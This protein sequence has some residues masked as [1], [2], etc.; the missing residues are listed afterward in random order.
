M[1]CLPN[2]RP[3]LPQPCSLCRLAD[4]RVLRPA[5]RIHIRLRGRVL[6][7]SAQ[8]ASVRSAAAAIVA[9][10]GTLV[11]FVAL[12]RG[13]GLT[14]VPRVIAPGAFVAL[15]AA[16]LRRRDTASSSCD[17][18]RPEIAE[19]QSRVS[20]SSTLNPTPRSSVNMGCTVALSRYSCVF[21][22]SS[23]C[24]G[25]RVHTGRIDE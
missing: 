6:R 15:R 9:A 17:V 8:P 25:C 13:F 11:V 3:R 10:F 12:L 2:L 19:P 4:L 24:N 22:R 16:I 21:Y 1:R 18:F 5:R 23:K 20:L 14:P 7:N